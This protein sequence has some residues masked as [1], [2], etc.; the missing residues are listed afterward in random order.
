MPNEPVTPD[1][2]SDNE[3]RNSIGVINELTN[4]TRP[5]SNRYLWIR[6]TVLAFIFVMLASLFSN[7][8]GGLVSDGL[9]VV[10]II[11]VV[12]DYVAHRRQY[13]QMLGEGPGT[14]APDSISLREGLI[15]LVVIVAC[16]ALLFTCLAN[17][18][19]Q[20]TALGVFGMR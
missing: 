2:H 3:R 9:L 4:P 13:L 17:T 10:F 15:M 7:V 6:R 14:L 19:C 18:S 5:A 12:T 20:T 11:W 16:F 8:E 1:T